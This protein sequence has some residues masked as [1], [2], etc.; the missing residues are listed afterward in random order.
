MRDIFD[1]FMDELR[2]RQAE[3][4]GQP[5]GPRRV[6]P[7]DDGSNGDGPDDDGPDD[8]GPEDREPPDR[9]PPPAA[10]RR[11]NRRPGGPRLRTWFLIIVA[12][13]VFLLLV[14]GVNL[15]TDAIWFRSVGFDSVFWTRIGA[16]S[17]LF[18]LGVVIAIVVLLANLWL[19][20][21]FSPPPT[22]GTRIGVRD[23]IDRL[24]APYRAAGPGRFD[25]RRPGAA[26]TFSSD[27]F[28][29]LTPATNWIIAAVA[30]L[31]ALGVGGSLA[32]SWETI[33]LWI[34]RVPFAPGGAA[35]VT[36]PIFGKDITFFLFELPFLRL[37][38][39][40]LNGLVIGSVIVAGARYLMGGGG[41]ALLSSTPV[42]AHLAVLAGLYL[43][44]IAF[45]YQLD[46]YELVYSN[47]G[48]ATGVSY[49][50]ANAQFIAY[51]VLTVLSAL[52][53][54]FLV[55]AAF[56]RWVWPL[57]ATILAW[58]IASLVIGSA[59]P[60]LIQRFVVTPNQFAQE[61]PY[62]RN[63]IAMTRL[64]F[65]L[66]SW[67]SVQYNGTAPLT[68]ATI[69]TESDTFNNAR[70]W[71]YRPLADTLGQLQ[72]IRRYYTFHDVDTDR[73]TIDSHER[74]VMLSARELD[75]SGN[76]NATG[77]VNERIVYT[78]GV[79]V[80][81]VPVNQ[82]TPEGQPEL[83]I[84]NLPPVSASGAPT[85]T[86]PR[87]YFG[88]VASEYVVVGAR[89]NEFDYPSSQTGA[90]TSGPETGAETR[91]SGTSGIKLDTV[92]SRLLFATRF[93]DL[94]LLI[95][96]QVTDGSQLL[97]H[98]SLDERLQLIAPFLR[99]DK[100]PY[101]AINGSGRL[102]Y[103]QDAYTVSDRFP[104][105]QDFSPAD[106]LGQTGLGTAP[107]NYIRNSVKV[108]MDAYDGSMTFYIAD[109]SDPIIRAYA[110]V[111]PNLFHPIS[112][113]PADLQP[114][115]R[116][117]EE[118]FD[119]ETRVFGRYHVP[120]PETFFR[121]DDLWTVPA[122]TTST[123]SL[124]SEAY[125]VVM[126]MPDQPSAEFL[127]LQPMVPKN[128]PNMIAWVA[129]RNDSPNYGKVR[130]FQFPDA[131]TIFGPAQI[132]AR[133][134]QDPI[135]S[136]QVSLWDQAGS[137]VIRGNLI[138][139][140]V[141]ESLIYLQPVYLQ[142]TSSSFPEF[143]KI[144]VASPTTVVW[145][146]T[147]S[148]ALNLLLNTSPGTTPSPPPGPTP[149]ATPGASAPPG[150]SASPSAGLPSDVP[151]LIAYANQHFELAQQALRDGDFARYGTEIDLVKQALARLQVLSGPTPL[152]A[153][154]PSSS[155]SP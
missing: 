56:T 4:A 29:D 135:I 72:T 115:L 101:V 17:G 140:P 20:A 154:S 130:V 12:L 147:L 51:D 142:S 8:D 48:V 59:Y 22:S 30:I 44:S 153:S 66:N 112:E 119:V 65:N 83:F 39:S 144:I 33:L 118:L 58:F 21:R 52:A 129:A 67:D 81:M 60:E 31:F 151:G 137:H 88:E 75:L 143:Q 36:D 87:I 104:H 11:V 53:A 109:P 121:N 27:D 5:Q 15:W 99:Y 7:D 3:G 150:P 98:R 54:A 49:T 24:G 19:A 68:Q 100:D 43:L 46:K 73:Y 97:M 16:T 84:Q 70:L 57:S 34:H 149:S 92:L 93:G 105:A 9:P 107:I 103:I 146:S 152:P 79:G 18:A 69:A 122:A 50:D 2:R 42:R 85:I 45:G 63:N 47:R 124:P 120:Q 95:S 32:G 94:D 38:Q 78:H 102:V 25:T 123:Q 126:R 127:L 106:E 133:I 1:E 128:R 82:V 74:Q 96:N 117:P 125:Y 131:T 90:A 80:A 136:A 139:V 14:F 110:G 113:L 76:P 28:P 155:P 61:E 134:D 40:V 89:Q 111:F 10:R 71:D 6:G 145:G 132:E 108:V 41:R 55:G 13:A 26:T 64:A 91:W 116:V 138:V 86:Q 77:W 37:V 23:F 148:Q 141:G 114:H 62:I 35:P